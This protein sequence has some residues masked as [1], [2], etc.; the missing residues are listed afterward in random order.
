MRKHL[1][2]T[3][4]TGF[5][6]LNFLKALCRSRYEFDQITLISKSDEITNFN[7]AE[8]MD[9]EEDLLETV[10]DQKTSIRGDISKLDAR[11][12]VNID[13]HSQ[14]AI[15]NFAAE[16]HVD[17]SIET[18]ADIFHSNT[19]IM[20]NLLECLCGVETERKFFFQ[21][22]TDEVYGSLEEDEQVFTPSSPLDPQ[23]PYAASKA[24]CEHLLR[25]YCNTFGGF[26]GF[27]FRLSNQ[28]GPHQ[29]PEKMIPHSID[30]ARQ[31]KPIE[32]YGDG[33]YWR[34]W[35]WVEESCDILLADICGDL[36]SEK[37][38]PFPP[39]KHVA[40]GNDKMFISNNQL[41][42]QCLVP[43]LREQGI[44]ADYTFVEDRPGHDRGYR[45][46]SD[47]V[48]AGTLREKVRK[49]VKWYLRRFDGEV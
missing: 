6:G 3:G 18:P 26:G 14:L 20:T 21:I 32:I 46:S 19:K 38:C 37:K 40:D 17:R 1:I 8:W 22:S 39:V 16:S 33:N 15:V 48:Y 43:A 35:S 10:A 30:L 34:Q 9:V 42:M 13:T 5:I 23:N 47:Y 11:D 27:I 2:V 25:S 7:H 4:D 44:D 36:A 29:F 28:F 49:V 24:A 12:F 45:I 41:V 31:G